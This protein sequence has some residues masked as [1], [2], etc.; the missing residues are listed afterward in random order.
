M[1]PEFCLCIL[2]LKNPTIYFS[3]WHEFAVIFW[4][5][6]TLFDHSCDCP[7]LLAWK[8]SR[9]DLLQLHITGNAPRHNYPTINTNNA[10]SIP[11]LR[12][13]LDNY[14]YILLGVKLSCLKLKKQ[15][16]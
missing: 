1:D 8:W 2:F 3:P 11:L 6:L 7:F 15:E 5:G 14:I 12:Y 16:E 13:A 10:I 4:N 9:E